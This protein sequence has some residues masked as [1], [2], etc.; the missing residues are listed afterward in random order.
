MLPITAGVCADATGALHTVNMPATAIVEI[1]A[2][3][4]KIAKTFMAFSNHAAL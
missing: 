3:Q 4:T 1:K 2:R